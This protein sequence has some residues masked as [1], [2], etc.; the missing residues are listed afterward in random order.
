MNGEKALPSELAALLARGYL[1]LTQ[2]R[3][4]L[5]VS[6]AGKP[7]LDLDLVGKKS[8]PVSERRAT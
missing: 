5:G 7:Q 6:G 2:S 3:N 1:R 4:N 8:P